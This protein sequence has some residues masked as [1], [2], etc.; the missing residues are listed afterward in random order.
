MKKRKKITAMICSALIISSLAACGNEKQ[1]YYLEQQTK[2]SNHDV[3]VKIEDITETTEA[4]EWESAQTAFD[5]INVGW[6]LGS[7]L[8][9]YKGDT[10]TISTQSLETSWGITATT[11][12][13]I[14]AIAAQGFG[15]VRIPVTYTNYMDENGNIQEFW[16]DRVEEVVN[17]V[18][19]NDMYC[20]I[21]VHHDTGSKG[22]IVAEQDC[23]DNNKDK[24]VNMWTQIANRFKDYD[25][26]LMFEGFNEVLDSE[27]KWSDAKDSAYEVMNEYNQLFVDTVRATGKNNAYR[28]LIVN[29]YAAKSENKSI[30]NFVL[31]DDSVENHIAVGVHIYCGYDSIAWFMDNLK[32]LTNKD[33]PIFVG[34]FGIQAKDNTVENRVK[35]VE[36]FLK[37]ASSRN[38][39]CAWWDDGF[40]QEG[41]EN[42]YNFALIN[43]KTYEWFFPEIVEVLT[44]EGKGAR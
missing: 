35:F 25:E 8:E 7:A 3:E 13:T 16:L 28:N 41:A 1:A 12:E 40:Q 43:R 42:V 36:T 27:Q 23:Y 19:D 2:P 39:T 31:P 5:N 9:C 37:E 22:W 4:D 11:K 29:T 33:I 44:R 18:I 30:N 6:N 20:V 15:M 21:N 10:Q 26:R 24:I 34:E 38:I 14:D 32:P 17:Y